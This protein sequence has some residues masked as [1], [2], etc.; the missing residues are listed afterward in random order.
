M[1]FSRRIVGPA[2]QVRRA[3]Y[4]VRSNSYSRKLKAHTAFT[5]IELLVVIAIISILAALLVPAVQNALDRAISVA[6]QSNLHQI[7]TAMIQYAGDHDDTMPAY[8]DNEKHDP[9]GPAIHWQKTIGVNY[10]GENEVTL[11]NPETILRSPLHCPADTK[12]PSGRIKGKPTRCIAINGTM[13]PKTWFNGRVWPEPVGATMAKIVLI[14]RPTEM[15][16][17]GDGAGAYFSNE[18]GNGARYYDISMFN[19][20]MFTRHM[21]GLNFVMMDGHTVR[22]DRTEFEYILTSQGKEGVFF[23]WAGHNQ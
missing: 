21:D 8:W 19:L 10:L 15:C 16:M 4:S 5:L 3:G 18:W 20:F 22:M 9:N 6:C 17:A 1:L 2:G 7:S 11:G 23:D 12:L 14:D 13:N